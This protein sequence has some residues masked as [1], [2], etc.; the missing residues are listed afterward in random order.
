MKTCVQNV[1]KGVGSV[2][3]LWPV[4]DYTRFVPASP[5]ELISKAWSTTGHALGKAMGQFEN[6]QKAAR[7]K[8]S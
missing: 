6:E 7:K 5:E 4:T 2:F 8:S 3:C 1:L